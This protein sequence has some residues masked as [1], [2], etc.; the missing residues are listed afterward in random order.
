MSAIDRLRKLA[1]DAAL[2]S[3]SASVLGWDQE[4]C[5]P[6]AGHP[7]RG[8]QLAWLAGRAHEMHTSREWADAVEAAIEEAATPRDLANFRRMKVEF[9]RA[10]RLPTAFVEREAALTSESKQAWSTARKNNDF[11]S[12]APFLSKLVELAREKADLLG[13]EGEAY[14]A[15]LEPYERGATAAGIAALFDDLGPRLREIAATAVERSR[16]HPAS[17][18]PGPYPVESQIELNRRIAASIGYDF[19]RG[20]IDT[21][22]HPFC[23]TLGPRDVRLTTRYDVNDFTSSLFGVLHEAGHGLYELG[24]REDDFGTPAGSAVSLGIHE[25]QSRLWENHVGRSPAFW[26][27]WLPEAASLFPQ[28]AGVS[29]DDF[30]AFIHRSA[31]SFIRVEADEATYDL[32]ILLR[33]SLERR[34]IRGDLAVHE[35]PEA[36]NDAFGELFGIRPPGDREGCLQDIHWSM[37]GLGYFPTYTLG[38]LNAAQLFE[39]A[40]G[41]PEIAG[42]V[43]AADYAP[44][45]GWLR[46]KVHEP[47]GS[48]DPAEIIRQATGREPGIEAHLAHLA[49]RY[50]GSI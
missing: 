16:Q 45:L 42:A 32:H 9:D 17:L 27:K 26:R 11:T 2:V 43:E 21:T 8:K 25:S 5:L 44:L 19:D 41:R 10:T 1:T 28:L 36:W 24:L 34:L 37:G 33:F 23:T 39:A 6:G 7:W 35:V 47:G 15:L 31:F 18:P 46:E 29:L 30:L 14:D 48:L 22:T 49:K 40:C 12:F 4:T 13:Y 3:S 38:N 20:R 50:G